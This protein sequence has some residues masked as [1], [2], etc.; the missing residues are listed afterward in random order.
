MV[1]EAPV[2]LAL[3]QPPPP[4]LLEVAFPQALV[5]PLSACCCFGDAGV[6]ALA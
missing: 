3:P 6:A 5:A 4:Q 1:V 2:C